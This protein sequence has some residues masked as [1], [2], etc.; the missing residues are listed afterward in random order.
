MIRT[1]NRHLNYAAREQALL[2]SR[3]VHEEHRSNT[4]PGRHEPAELTL[5]IPTLNERDNIEQLLQLLQ[6]ALE[7]VAWEV[8]FVDD[9]SRDGTSE[10]VRSI[11]RRNSR[12]RCIQRIDR[13]GLASACVEGFLSSAA[14]YLAVMDADLQHDETLLPQMLATLKEEP[15]DLVI[16]SRYIEGGQIGDFSPIRAWLSK[17]A[18]KLSHLVCNVEI[19]DPMSGFFMVRRDIFEA[20]L[21]RLSGQG[22]KIL[23]DL[24]A[25]SPRKL[26]VKELPFRFRNRQH[27]ASKLNSIV[28]LDFGSMLADKFFGG[29]LPVRFF[30]F[31]LVGFL[32][33]W[34]HM[35]VLWSAFRYLK[36]E[37]TLAQASATVSAIT[38]NFLLN[39]AFTY[40][41]LRL[42]GRRVVVGLISFYFVCLMG[43]FANLCAASYLYQRGIRWWLAG[44]SGIAIGSVWN[45]AVSSSIIW[46]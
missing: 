46:K 37:F 8:I 7:T 3:T 20:S 13:R 12:V 28:A 35:A 21:R 10:L 34:L 6:S 5:V 29:R 44:I 43:A 41:D 25:S 39:N 11:A 9:D 4:W 31:A 30:Q 38:L 19:A 16:G 23:F 2:D 24:V 45:Y 15:C 17:L 32:G 27:G 22:F 26:R 18:T 42:R 14:P 1:A 36:F 40:R 33:L